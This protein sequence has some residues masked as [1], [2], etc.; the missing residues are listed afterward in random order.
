MTKKNTPLVSVIISNW[1]QK[2]YALNCLE[3]HYMEYKYANDWEVNHKG[4]YEI[5]IF[6]KI[7]PWQE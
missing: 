3:N 4:N 6:S 1:N 2:D 5:D 7:F